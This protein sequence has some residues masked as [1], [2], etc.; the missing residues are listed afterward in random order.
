MSTSSDPLPGSIF[1]RTTGVTREGGDEAEV[2]LELTRRPYPDDPQLAFL[3][4]RIPELCQLIL[5][6]PLLRASLRRAATA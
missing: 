2:E 5:R 1:V 3:P 4:L 6:G